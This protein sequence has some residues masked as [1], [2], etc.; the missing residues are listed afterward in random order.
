MR[1]KKWHRRAMGIMGALALGVLLIFYTSTS[2]IDT[3]PYFETSYYRNT[4]KKM[5]D[6]FKNTMQVKGGLLAGFARINITPHTVNDVPEP[7]KGKFNALKLAG[8]GDGKIAVGVHDSIFAKAIALEVNGKEIIF[9]SA[10]LL[11]IPET[12]VAHVTANLGGDLSREQLFFGATHTHSSIGHCIPGF[13]GESF[14]GDFRPEVVAW[15]GDAF[16]KLILKARKDKKIARFSSGTIRTPNLVRNR[17]IGETGRVNDRLSLVS[18]EQESGKKAVVG[19]FAAHATTIGSWNNTYSGDYP[20]YFQ[21]NLE[22]KG[23]DLALFFAGTVGSHS[24]N[25]KGEKFDRA[26][27]VGE[28]LADSAHIR[29]KTMQHDSI[30]TMISATIALEVPELQAVYVTDRL[31]LSPFLAGKLMPKMKSI[32]LQGIRLNDLVWITMPYELSGEYGIDLKNALAVEGYKS[33]LTSFNGQYLGYIVP[34]K[35][36]YFK[37]YEPRLMGWYGPT[38]G[39]YLMELKFRLANGLTGTKL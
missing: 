37:H 39:D 21:R 14:G 5:D 30:I 28:T 18:F 6:T 36:Y 13:V 32:H 7:S 3:T 26:R 29:L 16:V 27:Y 11:S 10:D 9:I 1:T 34:Q 35:Y 2:T 24:H 12:V 38:M 20:G 31:R 22:G 4:I 19:I 25:G 8:F 23:I 17:I 15:L 33:A